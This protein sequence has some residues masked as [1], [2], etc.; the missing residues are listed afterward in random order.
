MNSE[1]SSSHGKRSGRH[2]QRRR[3]VVLLVAALA[4][5]ITA[6]G[7]GAVL[8]SRGGGRSVAAGCT[9]STPLRVAAT[10]ELFPVVRAVAQRLSDGRCD[11][12]A[13]QVTAADSAAL[14]KRLRAG[15][16][17]KA[18]AVWIPDSA[19]WLSGLPQYSKGKQAP[20]IA[21]SPVV[22][23][24]AAETAARLGAPPTLARLAATSI[25]P[26]PVLLAAANVEGCAATQDAVTSIYATAHG[27]PAGWGVLA[28][29]LRTSSAAPASAGSTLPTTPPTA[30]GSP[31]ALPTS[32]QAVFAANRAARHQAYTGLY[33]PGPGASLDFPYAV[34]T[35]DPAE[36]STAAALLDGLRSAA[37]QT[38]L[39]DAGFR[40]ST[41]AAG[42][43]LAHQPGVDPTAAA[44]GGPDATQRSA[45]LAALRTVLRPARLLA[46]IDVSGSMASPIPGRTG[47]TRISVAR[48]AAAQAI[49][50]LPDDSVAGLWEFATNLT[51]RTDYR[52][53]VPMTPLNPVTRGLVT[54]AVNTLAAVPDGGTG[55][56]DSV[57]AAVR[58]VRAQYDPTR[59]NSVVV[60]T[61]GRDEDDAAHR[62][63]LGTL[64][65]A[66]R[67]ERQS[68]RPVRVITIG[69]GPAS[70]IAALRQIS[71]ASGGVAY[72]STDPR[73][74]P[75]IFRAVIGH[76]FCGS[77][78]R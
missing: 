63:E 40:S 66:L 2:R 39:L 28:A 20:S 65:D 19:R 30:S 52:E 67:S 16:R 21:R 70:D 7:V 3:P 68:N 77:T 71:A 15:D 22:L 45:A 74:V 44:T 31:E 50:L 55:L 29:F 53:L 1:P 23:A 48:D 36:R 56:Y 27:E 37:G 51:P 26:Q 64:L 42:P 38:T 17:S 69:Y 72:H 6:G 5:L 25:T 60:L 11:G 13:V 41:G 46:L 58:A 8:L 61:D 62:I 34:L 35:D 59:V 73:D 9:P 10:A 12:R 14:A 32:E 4:V 24:V 78:C 54:T 57:L 75:A 18:P 47:S 49:G 43:A 76:R 33:L